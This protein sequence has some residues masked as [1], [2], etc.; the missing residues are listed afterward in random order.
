MHKWAT[1]FAFSFLLV[2]CASRTIEPER[3]LPGP[4]ESIQL[5]GIDTSC[6]WKTKPFIPASG[7]N[8]GSVASLQTEIQAFITAR[9]CAEIAVAPNEQL[10]R[11]RFVERGVA[12][13]MHTCSL[14]FDSLER[15]RVD[16]SYVQT[17]M[18][19]VGTA[20][21]AILAIGGD[22]TRAIFN[23]ATG[24][25]LGNAWFENYKAN[26]VMTPNLG[27]VHAK[28]K[29][30]LQEPFAEVLTA[31]AKKGYETFDLALSEMYEFDKLCSHKSIVVLLDRAVEAA[32]VIR[33]T[34]APAPSPADV[35]KAE[36]IKQLLY[37]SA[38]GGTK[39][40]FTKEQFVLLYSLATTPDEQREAAAES[41]GKI[42]DGLDPM[43][44][45]LQLNAK[46]VPI[47]VLSRFIAIDKLLGTSSSPDIA[48]ARDAI[49][50]QTT[51]IKHSP[52]VVGAAV[53]PANP[54]SN[55]TDL[56]ST[57]EALTN[58]LT[59]SPTQMFNASGKTRFD[60]KVK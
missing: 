36:D 17:N 26:Y 24:L 19:I 37:A 28:L 21:T 11:R 15:R 20:V 50:S 38:T 51:K 23:I 42:S 58:V 53:N 46:T 33:Y 31:K 10:W 34:D 2:G 60:Y 13:S 40:T 47:E 56:T 29:T 44:K 35:A 6:A 25:T 12:L 5:T 3:I 41:A 9:Y 30:E 49:A 55:S 52:P 45:K 59:S 18:N 1:V 16:T 54:M 8:A 57:R 48:A 43:I 14:F 39:G 7:E 4:S 32:Q 27:K 22:H